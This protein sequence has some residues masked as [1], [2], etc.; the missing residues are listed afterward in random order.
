MAGWAVVTGVHGRKSDL[1][2]ID[3][4]LPFLS[5]FDFLRFRSGGGVL[6]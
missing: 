5:T 3:G 6:E 1:I 2:L 4:G